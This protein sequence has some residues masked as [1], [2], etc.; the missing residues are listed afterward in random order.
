MQKKKQQKKI[1]KIMIFFYPWIFFVSI[2]ISAE[3]QTL[4]FRTYDELLR[5]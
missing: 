1:K 4:F 2:F 3:K 5:L